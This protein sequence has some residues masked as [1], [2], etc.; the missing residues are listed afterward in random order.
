[1]ETVTDTTNS[2][3]ECGDLTVDTTVRLVVAVSSKQRQSSSSSSSSSSQQQQQLNESR[4]R[5]IGRLIESEAHF[6]AQLSESVAT[7]TRPLRGFFLE[8][9][10]YFALFQN[11]EKILVISE[12]FL[13]SMDKWSAQ[14]L[15]ARIGQLYAQKLALFREAYAQYAR[16]HARALRL[17]AELRT[18]SRQFRLF[19]AEAQHE[20]ALTMRR[21]LDAPVRH[22]RDTLSVFAELRRLTRASHAHQADATHIDAV[23]GHLEAILGHAETR[24]LS[25]NEAE[26]EAEEDE[27]ELCSASESSFFMT[28]SSIDCE[29]TL[30]SGGSVGTSSSSSSSQ[31]SDCTVCSADSILNFRF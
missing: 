4:T 14:D 23:C 18:H 26:T 21:L 10:D 22:M 11:V 20:P 16:G 13:R 27:E 31:H 30:T 15:Y 9:R 2:Y 28:E 12:N 6:V 7:F 1:M 25:L 8:Q 24:E 19:L 3:T 29:A 5:L 17:L